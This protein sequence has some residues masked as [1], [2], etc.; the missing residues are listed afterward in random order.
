MRMVLIETCK[1]DFLLLTM[2]NNI[3]IYIYNENF[4]FTEIFPEILY[5]YIL[6]FHI[7]LNN[8]LYII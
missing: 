8:I 5:F 4:V 1:T 7:L 2:L 3:V 6:K